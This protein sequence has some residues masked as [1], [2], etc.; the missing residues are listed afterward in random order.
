MISW[1]GRHALP[2]A[3]SEGCSQWTGLLSLQPRSEGLCPLS[4]GSARAAWLAS[5]TA[6]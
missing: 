6:K 3:L 1:P 2:R 4:R 5:N